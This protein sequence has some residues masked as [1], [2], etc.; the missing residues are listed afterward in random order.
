[1]PDEAKRPTRRDVLTV[2][3][4][5]VAALG[6]GVP[7][8]GCKSTQNDAAAAQGAAKSTTRKT[9][10][11]ARWSHPIPAFD[12]WFNEQYCKDWGDAHNTDVI[13]DNLG[14]TA[15]EAAAG[16]EAASKRGHDLF[17]FARPMPAYEDEVID[18]AAVYEECWQRYGKAIDLA[19]RSTQ[20]PQTKKYF[21]FAESFAPRPI[22]YRKDL[23]DEVGGNPDTWDDIRRFG[24]K[25][26]DKRG[27]P[28]ALGL[29]ADIDTA[30]VL[31]AVLYSFGAS[32]QNAEGSVA[33]DSNET[34]EAVTFFKALYRDAMAPD[35]LSAGASS[36]GRAIIEGKASVVMSPISVTRTAEDEGV[37]IA[38]NIRLA[39]AARGPARRMAP[40][41]SMNCYSIWKFAKNIDG[42]RAFLADYVGNLREGFLHSAFFNMPCFPTAPDLAVL[43]KDDSLGKPPDKYTA[44]GDATEWTTNGGYPGYT[45][46]AIADADAASALSAMFARASTG[47]MSPKDAIQEAAKKYEAIWAKWRAHNFL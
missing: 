39:K 1:M 18:H 46:A 27:I 22:L 19:V 13:V 44:L 34:L 37:P 14:I 3:A 42:A 31:R 32:E 10:R 9:L 30:N 38:E 25:I 12:R 16:A 29:A 11:I 36:N 45:N 15:L 7:L 4:L 5:G 8:T 21:A 35:A 33:L 40:A 41:H 20:N 26:K 28:V 6:A 43:V 17:A 47:A 2:A 24:K 23:F